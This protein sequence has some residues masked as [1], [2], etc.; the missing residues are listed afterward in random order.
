L[1]F[2]EEIETLNKKYVNI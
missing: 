1:I 2:L